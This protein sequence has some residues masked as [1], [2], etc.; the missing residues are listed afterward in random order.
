M[1]GDAQRYLTPRDMPSF[2]AQ[3]HSQMNSFNELKPEISKKYE[4][5]PEMIYTYGTAGFRMK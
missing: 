4:K 1:L 5:D 3:N 2:I